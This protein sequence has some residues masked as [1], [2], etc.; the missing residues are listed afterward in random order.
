MAWMKNGDNAATYPPLMSIAGMPEADERIINEASGFVWRAATQ[1]AAHST[2]YIVEMGTLYMLGGSRTQLLLTLCE[3]AGLM[4]KESLDSGMIAYKIIADPEFINI[5]LR[6]EIEWERQQ[7]NDTRDPGLTI[8]VRLRDGDNCRWCGVLVHWRGKGTARSGEY[9]H[10]H[11]G[12]AGA[13]ATMYVSCRGCNAGRGANREAWDDTHSRRPAP[14]QPLY[15]RWTADL[16]QKN[17]Y[18]DVEAN[19]SSDEDP[20]TGVATA[21]APVQRQADPIATKVDGAREV[22][23]P[24]LSPPEVISK[25]LRQSDNTSIA[26]SGRDGTG[27]VVKGRA[28]SK[29]GGSTQ[30]GTTWPTDEGQSVKGSAGTGGNRRRRG[31]RGGQR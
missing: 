31:R 22:L 13:V 2:D 15:G 17:G 10:Q 21:A 23:S 12:E 3:R 14:K 11:P 28:G 1:S 4:T 27:S 29:R 20:Q 8:P 16:L 19:I 5:R 25:S 24:S 6:A 26:G 9:D 7:R 18:P 30:G